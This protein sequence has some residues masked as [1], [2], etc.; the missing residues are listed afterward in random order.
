MDYNPTL[1]TMSLHSDSVCIRFLGRGGHYAQLLNPPA[2]LAVRRQKAF[3]EDGAQDRG[4]LQWKVDQNN[5]GELVSLA[6]HPYLPYVG[7][8]LQKFFI[9]PRKRSII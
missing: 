2:A 9:C 3:L 8:Q 1:K 5:Q 4:I 6:L 7:R